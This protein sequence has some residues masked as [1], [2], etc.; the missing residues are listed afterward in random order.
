MEKIQF[1]KK[2]VLALDV[3]SY[4]EALE[5]VR[6]CQDE[7]ELYLV[8]SELFA[9]AGPSVVEAIHKIGKKVFLDLKHFDT[10]SVAARAVSAL[11]KQNVFILTV[12]TRGGVDMMKACADSLVHLS[13]TTGMPRPLVLGVTL[14]NEPDYTKL[15]DEIGYHMG[16]DS[17]VKNLAN[18]AMMAGLDG[19]TASPEMI[20]LIRQRC[21]SK[22]LIAARGIKPFWHNESKQNPWVT[23]KKALRQGADYIIMDATSLDLSNLLDNIRNTYEELAFI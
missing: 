1:L 4:A 6:T 3:G 8:G 19:V 10:P 20:Q 14:F 22:F 9:Q 7:V 2:F 5:I 23:P 16:Q 21:G 15:R 11:A 12:H 18:L 17:Q 13:L